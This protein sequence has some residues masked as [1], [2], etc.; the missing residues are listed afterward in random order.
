M[1]SRVSDGSKMA[2]IHLIDHLRERNFL[3]FD[4]QQ[5]NDH[6]RSLGAKE[7]P[8]RE[9]LQLLKTAVNEKTMF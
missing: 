9:Y 1:F 8:R 3:L 5:A 7:I 4:I 2:L 6:T